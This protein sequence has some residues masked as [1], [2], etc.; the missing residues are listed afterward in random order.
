MNEFESRHDARGRE[1]V[2]A[3][4]SQRAAQKAE[5]RGRIA[6]AALDEFTKHGFQAASMGAIAKRAHIARSTVHFHFQTKA[7]LANEIGLRHVDTWK[8]YYHDFGALDPADREAIERW[9]GRFPE[10]RAAE[11]PVTVVAFQANVI[12]TSLGQDFADVIREFS[13]IAVRSA[14]GAHHV[15]SDVEIET[16][17]F[18]LLGLDRYWY[19][20]WSQEAEFSPR[21]DDAIVTFAQM[22]LSI[23]REPALTK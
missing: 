12:D 4:P 8:G 15:P 7:E 20:R 5:T 3:S 18:L 10:L 21:I 13:R 14:L 6:Q 11:G 2:N 22:T 23:I 9:L 1:L 17:R 19:L 16:V